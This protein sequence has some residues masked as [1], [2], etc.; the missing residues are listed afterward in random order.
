MAVYRLE[1][2]KK[3]A[4][5]AKIEY[6]GRIV[7][8]DIA[9][10]GYDLNDVI[11]CMMQLSESNFRKTHIYNNGIPSDDDYTCQYTRQVDGE[12]LTD[13][14]YIKFCLVDDC[15]SIDLGSFHLSR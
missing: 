1:D 11:A 6:R 4:S 14:L 15:L 8:R 2:V 7:Q 13:D 12:T 3:A 10:L 9:N 5:A